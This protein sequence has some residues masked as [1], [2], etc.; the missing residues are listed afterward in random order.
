VQE[1]NVESTRK[2]EHDCGSD[3]TCVIIEG[4]AQDGRWLK[5]SG[6]LIAVVVVGGER[7]FG[8]GCVDR[9]VDGF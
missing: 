9:E 6:V 5:L 1:P 8:W 7:G 3:Q 2:V 4:S